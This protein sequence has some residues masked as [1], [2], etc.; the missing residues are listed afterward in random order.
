[1]RHLFL[2]F[3]GIGV[4]QTLG[5]ATIDG[6]IRAWIAFGFLVLGMVFYFVD[7]KQE[8]TKYMERLDNILNERKY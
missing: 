8:H 1:M 5:A 4:G 7:Q 3:A 6:S 2:I